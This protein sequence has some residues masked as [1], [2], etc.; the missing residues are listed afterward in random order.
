MAA[1]ARSQ[2]P[3]PDEAGDLVE[4]IEALCLLRASAG[5]PSYRVLARRVS[6]LMRPPQQVSPFTVV[7]VFK[8]G[9]RR[10]DLDLVLAIVRALGVEE[11]DVG[12]WREAC[13]RAHVNAKR[14]T[15]GVLRQLPADLGSFAGRQRVLAELLDACE[16]SQDAPARTVVISAIE[17]MAGVGKTRLALR[18]A[19]QLVQAGR[20]GE[21][22][23]YADLRGFD[24]QE[25]PADPSDVL[26]A[27]LRQLGTAPGQIPDSLAERA[28]MFRDR[29]AGQAAMILLDNA[30]DAQQVRDLI[31]AS[32]SCLVL[33]TSR[34][35]L[36]DLEGASVLTLDVFSPQ[37]AL[38]LLCLVIGAE[39]VAAER[40]AA[41]QLTAACGQLP[42]AVSIIAARLRS[43]P[44]WSLAEMARQLDGG[45]DALAFRGRSLAK[46]F[47][48]SYLGLPTPTRRLFRMLGSH[49]GDDVTEHSAA[50]FAGTAVDETR[51]MLELLL[52]EHL[53]EQRVPGRY[54]MHDL[55][56]AFARGIAEED[57][58]AQSA[59]AIRRLATWYIHTVLS[60]EAPLHT[61]STGTAN[62]DAVPEPPFPP[63]RFDA[64]E[65]GMAWFDL[66]RANVIA[67]YFRLA[68]E[69]PSDLIAQFAYALGWLLRIRGPFTEWRAI[70]LTA[71]RSLAPDSD[72]ILAGRIYGNAGVACCHL[73]RFEEAIGYFESA[74]TLRRSAGDAVGAATVLVNL[75]GA[76]DELERP[77]RA[78]ECRLEAMSHFTETGN[79]EGVAICLVNLAWSHRG[80]NR[81]EE[82]IGYGQRALAEY[83]ELG[84]DFGQAEALCGLGVYHLMLDRA[85]EALPY[86]REALALRRR[87]GNRYG[88]ADAL[89]GLGDAYRQLRRPELAE[90][91]WRS[92]HTIFSDLGHP[93][94]SE[95]ASLLK[96]LDTDES[97]PAD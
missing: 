41:E 10:L 73:A 61:A 27:F 26:D 59:A 12:R 78:V 36:A 45:L 74:L 37:E 43:R 39:R 38:E 75:G 48:L 15:A 40:E 60:A 32:T 89:S 22:Q 3:D 25:P 9:R 31:P 20:Y 54:R 81:L 84:N 68:E 69:D 70:L 55:V 35:S 30:A 80:L 88:Q 56:R 18:A 4:F 76:Y 2:I 24:P 93:R 1:S 42:L 65:D 58:E 6:A 33:V 17:G 66:E 14:G 92:A 90:K 83:R 71:I 87:T 77:E 53:L 97:N 46:V 49:P 63:L 72:P 47:D 79:R 23:L 85:Q 44:T 50:A 57:P 95:L 82:A 28:A 51:D 19:H 67:A 96:D 91:A 16:P 5:S 7:D 29:T 62:H 8:T 52:D 13:V 86:F 11:A 34:R 94:V 21:M 64:Q